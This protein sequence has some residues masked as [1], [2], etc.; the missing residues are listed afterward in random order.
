MYSNTNTNLNMKTVIIAVTGTV[1]TTPDF[2]SNLQLDPKSLSV[3]LH[4]IGKACQGKTLQPSG[5]ICKLQRQ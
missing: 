5:P 3:T 2:F 4:I 1:F